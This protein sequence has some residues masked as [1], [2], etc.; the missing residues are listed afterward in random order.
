MKSAIS[1]F[2]YSIGSLL[3]LSAQQTD[4]DSLRLIWSDTTQLDS[5][6][7]QA[8]YKLSR[9]GYLYSQP[10]SSFYYAQKQLEFAQS[11]GIDIYA[12]SALNTQGAS[13]W[14][15]SDYDNAL[16]Y[17]QKSQT[18][19]EKIGDKKG[20]ASSLNNLGMVYMSNGQLW[21]CH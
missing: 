5:I 17:F 14:I 20:R 12:A 16:E 21:C 8:I 4:L 7:L 13:F 6:R 11:K 9:E 19:S 3:I 10:D 15:K 18:I 1:F 2:L